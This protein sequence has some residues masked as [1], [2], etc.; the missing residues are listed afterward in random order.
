MEVAHLDMDVRKDLSH[1]SPA[2]EDD[3]QEDESRLLQ[4]LSR[5]PIHRR[6]LSSDEPPD[7][8]PFQ[9]RS[10]EHEHP[11]TPREERDICGKD[12]GLRGNPFLFKDD[13]VQTFLDPWDTPSVLLRKLHE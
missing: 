4:L 7:D 13:A 10:S 12:E 2:V 6:V 5:F 3:G 1:A 11:V 8:V 9:S